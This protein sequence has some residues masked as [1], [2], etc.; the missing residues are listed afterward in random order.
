MRAKIILE[1]ARMAMIIGVVIKK[2]TVVPKTTAAATLGE[3]N[4][5]K[6]IATWEPRVK[7]IGPKITLGI[8]MGTTRPIAH[9]TPANTN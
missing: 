2:P 7:D 1:A 3:I 9:K 4:M 8:T 6:K 5:T